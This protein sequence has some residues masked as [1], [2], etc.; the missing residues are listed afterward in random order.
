MGV[1]VLSEGIPHATTSLRGPSTG[2]AHALP[3]ILGI[4]E[5]PGEG[6]RGGDGEG[7]AMTIL[8]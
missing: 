4:L 2:P 5:G 8:S 7:G 1:S 3:G 6:L